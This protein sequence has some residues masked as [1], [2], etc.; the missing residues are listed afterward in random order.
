KLVIKE[1]F[2]N[3]DAIIPTLS[4]LSFDYSPTKYISNPL[5]CYESWEKNMA[6]ELC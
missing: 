2:Q 1:E 6:V 3:A 4:T 5:S